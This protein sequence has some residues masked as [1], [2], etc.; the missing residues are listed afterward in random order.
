METSAR[1]VRWP[2]GEM[3]VLMACYRADTAGA[4]TVADDAARAPFAVN[5]EPRTP[6]PSPRSRLPPSPNSPPSSMPAAR[7]TTSSMPCAWMAAASPAS[8]RASLPANPKAQHHRGGRRRAVRVHLHQ[9]CRHAGRVLDPCLRP[10]D[11]RRGV[12]ICTHHG[13]PPAWRARP[14]CRGQTLTASRPNWP[15]CVSPSP[16]RRSSRRRT[17]P[18][19]SASNWPGRRAIT[20]VAAPQIQ[21]RRMRWITRLMSSSAPVLLA[22][23]PHVICAS[24]ACGW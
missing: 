24:G 3:I 22:S 17:S 1:H 13:G 18:R 11:Q 12:G 6:R 9:R 2:D 15:T 4:I 10:H 21:M 8:R 20:D 14:G 16:T 19:M 23:S 7:A 5:T